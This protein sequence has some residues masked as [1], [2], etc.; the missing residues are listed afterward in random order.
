M[1]QA[2]GGIRAVMDSVFGYFVPLVPAPEQTNVVG[3]GVPV[4]QIKSNI[5]SPVSEST[6]KVAL[7]QQN[8]TAKINK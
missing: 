4:N 2:H 7:A 3:S 6:R 1:E 5:F 8:K